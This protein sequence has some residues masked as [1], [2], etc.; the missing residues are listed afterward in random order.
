MHPWWLYAV[1]PL[2]IHTILIHILLS[3]LWHLAKTDHNHTIN[4][5][6][7]DGKS[8]M[9]KTWWQCDSQSKSCNDHW[10]TLEK[11]CTLLLHQMGTHPIHAAWLVCHAI[12]F[13]GRDNKS[14]EWVYKKCEIV[15]ILCGSTF[16][17]HPCVPRLY[18]NFSSKTP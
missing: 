14:L 13:K 17:H 11:H 5:I 9:Y 12:V 8:G 10:C 2:A 15:K 1:S 6:C 7:S 16:L 3:W 18:W 4:V